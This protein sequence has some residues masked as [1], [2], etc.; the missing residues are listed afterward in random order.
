MTF[1]YELKRLC[2]RGAVVGGEGRS[3]VFTSLFQRRALPRRS[4]RATR[5][6]A[7]FAV[8]LCSAQNLVPVLPRFGQ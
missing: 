5:S 7:R 8:S 3:P 2:L 1:G 4:A 6:P